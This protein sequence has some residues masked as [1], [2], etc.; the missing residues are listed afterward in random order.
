MINRILSIISNRIKKS[1]KNY[2]CQTDTIQSYAQY[3]EDL[4]IDSLLGCKQKGMYIDIGANDPNSLSNTKRFYNRGWSGINIEPDP[5]SFGLLEKF[6]TNDLNL[7]IAVGKSRDEL[8]FYISSI[9][10]LSSFS[11]RTI[12]KNN[13]I[14]NGK[15]VGV[16]KISV[17]TLSYIFDKYI[18]ENGIDFMSIDVEGFE[19]QVLESNDWTK[20][21]PSLLIVETY[22]NKHEIISFL[23]KQDYFLAFTNHTNSIFMKREFYGDHKK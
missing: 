17:Y 18:K 12:D 2:I 19:A 7:N 13:R 6:R 21:R 23:D 16:K 5:E 3:S 14:H 10:T 11:K 4:I 9:S 22:Y 8:L 20:Y 1:E 15:I